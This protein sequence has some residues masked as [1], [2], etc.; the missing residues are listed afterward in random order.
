M[1]NIF[2]KKTVSYEKH[3]IVS[4][5]HQKPLLSFFLLTFLLSPV[6]LLGPPLIAKFFGEDNTAAFIGEVLVSWAPGISALVI[7]ALISGSAGVIQLFGQYF[8]WKIAFR[9]YAIAIVIPVGAMVIA[10]LVITF[11][12]GKPISDIV[13]S[14]TISSL[15]LLFLNHII[16]GCVLR[17]RN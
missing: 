11:W 14:L 4:F 8:K 1:E 17:N 3:G 5:L 16:R 13:N 2:I 7:V 12:S 15:V 10:I 9:Y 6:L